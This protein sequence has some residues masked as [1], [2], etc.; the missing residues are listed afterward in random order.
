[1]PVYQPREQP[2]DF[3]PEVMRERIQGALG[4]DV[5]ELQITSLSTWRMTA[6]VAKAYRKDRVLLVGDAA[7]RFPPTGSL[8]MNTGITAAHNM[9]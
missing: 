3:T 4:F 9:C 1:M 2:E 6:Q 5:P 8:G 7:H